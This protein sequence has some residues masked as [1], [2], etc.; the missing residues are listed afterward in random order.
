MSD[1]H[2]PG[3]GRPSA[4]EDPARGRRHPLAGELRSLQRVVNTVR[5]YGL[6]H[7]HAREQTRDM[8]ERIRPL[9]DELGGIDLEITFEALLFEGDV[10][11]SEPEPGGMVDE[12]YRDG[13]RRLTLRSGIDEEEMLELL[14]ILGTN[15]AL[16]EHQE[17]SLQGLLWAANLPHVGYEAIKGIEEAAED[18]ADAARGENLDFEAICQQIVMAGPLGMGQAG[19]PILKGLVEDGQEKDQPTA[20][21]VPPEDAIGGD[22]QT[23]APRLASDDRSIAGT[24]AQMADADPTASNWRRLASLDTVDFVE[25]KRSKLD[26]AA[27]ELLM[28]WDEAEADTFG[29]LLDRTVEVLVHTA[30]AGEAGIDVDRAAPLIEGCLDQASTE[31]LIRRY[32]ST[33]EEMIELQRARPS[34][35]E[36]NAAFGLLTRLLRTDRILR[37]AAQLDREDPEV[38]ASLET[39][40]R[41]GGDDTQRA[42]LDA[43]GDVS[44]PIHRR[45]LVERVVR[46]IGDDAA[47]LTQQIRRLDE[48][49]LRVRLE[50]LASMGSM[51]ARD[52]LVALLGHANPAVRRS[53][54]ELVP[55]DYLRHIWK[56]VIP[57]LAND[58]D[59]E[60]RCAVMRR[61]EAEELGALPGLLARMAT[62]DSFHKR[63]MV[64]KDLALSI[65]A[66]TGGAAAVDT[67]TK[68]LHARVGIA[69]PRQAETRRLAALALAQTGTIEARRALTKAAKTWEP[70]LRKAASEALKAFEGAG[71]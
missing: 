41:L 63:E 4:E 55:A 30:V 39:V 18:S 45:F 11:V 25:G 26:V 13:I 69:S 52:Q 50:A 64:E 59:Q 17:D 3:D 68:M 49:R 67:L 19:D 54:I 34:T 44:E 24:L 29:G 38:A 33:I 28:L 15:F 53:V 58:R 35:A 61:A 48:R 7:E 16:P 1:P 70:G 9:L 22:L 37:F 23:N 12:L 65:L 8:I 47:S 31:G 21:D 6:H 40:L 71:S 56:R 5:L 43:L 10:V 66:R 46:V 27:D 51:A 2:L 32:T 62:A 57:M 36:A 14:A 60:V 42:F 20:P